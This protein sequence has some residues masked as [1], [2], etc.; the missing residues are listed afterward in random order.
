M[1]CGAEKI[2][3]YLQIVIY[4]ATRGVIDGVVCNWRYWCAVPPQLVPYMADAT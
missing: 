3:M 2:G 1:M 4:I